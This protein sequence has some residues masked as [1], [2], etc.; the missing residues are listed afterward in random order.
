MDTKLELVQDCKFIQFSP[1]TGYRKGC[2]CSRC[3]AAKSAQLKKRYL[4]HRTR[5]LAKQAEWCAANREYK[6]RKERERRKNNP[7]KIKDGYLRHR[8]GITLDQFRSMG[9]RCMICHSEDRMMVD[10]DHKTGKV[11]GVLCHSCNIGIGWLRDSTERLMAA[12][13]YLK[14]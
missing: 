14:Q 3:K 10:H 13:A 4:K 7:D 5:I 11:R 9:S 12:V 6:N 1:I 2:R 8:Y